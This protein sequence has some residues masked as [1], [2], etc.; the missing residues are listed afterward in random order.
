MSLPT[1]K[2][3]GTYVH[4]TKDL[5]KRKCLAFAQNECANNQDGSCVPLGCPCFAFI[6]PTQACSYFLRVVIP[7][8]EELSAL[9][10]SMEQVR[11]QG[12]I[13]VCQWC[14]KPFSPGSNRQIYCL[15]CGADMK[16]EKARLRKR[17]E[18]KCHALE[19]GTPSEQCIN[20][21]NAGQLSTS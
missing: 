3:G 11:R 13:K 19:Q 18:R 5:L 4:M 21:E 20:Q 6:P 9:L 8:D 16:R 15:Q 10:G 17:E 7:L 14:G 2:K 12:N 1:T